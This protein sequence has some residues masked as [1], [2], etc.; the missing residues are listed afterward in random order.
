MLDDDSALDDRLFL[1]DPLL[2]ADAQR[3]LSVPCPLCLVEIGLPCWDADLWGLP[4]F[5]YARLD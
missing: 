3:S 5:H 4:G 2:S 1:A